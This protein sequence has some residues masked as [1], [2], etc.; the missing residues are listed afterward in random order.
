MDELIPGMYEAVDT[1]PGR[2][3]Y[4]GGSTTGGAVIYDNGKF[5]TAPRH[6]PV[7]RAAGQC[8]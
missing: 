7:Q 4:L 6:R 3:T 8:L 5:F 1:M 2:Y